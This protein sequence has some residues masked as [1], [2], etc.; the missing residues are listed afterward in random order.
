MDTSHAVTQIIF[1][2]YK[3]FAQKGVVGVRE[4][5]ARNRT[6]STP[7]HLTHTA[8]SARQGSSDGKIP[9]EVHNLLCGA[10]SAVEIIR[11]EWRGS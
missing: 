8:V 10:A 5:S 1:Q 6:I 7:F 9:G 3:E 2:P 4:R 11:G